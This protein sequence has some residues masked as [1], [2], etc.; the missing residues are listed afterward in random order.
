MSYIFDVP[1]QKRLGSARETMANNFAQYTPPKSQVVNLSSLQIQR[2][3]HSKS[4]SKNVLHRTM[5]LV[6]LLPSSSTLG[7]ILK[8]K[9]VCC[10]KSAWF[11]GTLLWPTVFPTFV[12]LLTPAW[13]TLLAIFRPPVNP[14]NW[15]GISGWQTRHFL[16]G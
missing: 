2:R 12:A 10:R 8:T 14:T 7:K 1:F 15:C 4:R 11:Q 6:F 3:Q 9:P 13:A 16:N 5:I